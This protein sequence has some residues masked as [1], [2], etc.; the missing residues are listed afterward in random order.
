MISGSRTGGKTRRERWQDTIENGGNATR[1]GQYCDCINGRGQCDA[2]K[3]GDNN[4]SSC[5]KDLEKIL[6][7]CGVF[8]SVING[9]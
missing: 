6:E 7:F 2:M 9:D 4:R 1:T 3:N 5:D 8:F